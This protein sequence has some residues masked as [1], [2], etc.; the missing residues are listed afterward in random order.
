MV[1]SNT[2]LCLYTVCVWKIGPQHRSV[3]FWKMLTKVI[4]I[5]WCLLDP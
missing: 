3:H 5:T 4:K 2:G 1:P